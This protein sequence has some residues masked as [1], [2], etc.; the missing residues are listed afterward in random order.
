MLFIMLPVLVVFGND[1]LYYAFNGYELF[2]SNVFPSLFPFLVVVGCLV[3]LGAFRPKRRF[4]G[5]EQ[6]VRLL[7]ELSFILPLF[8][9]AAL[10]GAPSGS[11]LV[12]SALDGDRY[13]LAEKSVLSAFLNLCCPMFLLTTVSCRFL[14]RTVVPFGLILLVSH[15]SAS[16]L[17]TVGFV[18]YKYF[19]EKRDTCRTVG[20]QSYASVRLKVDD[21]EPNTACRIADV[22]PFAVFD[23]VTTMLKMLGAFV[24]FCVFASLTEKA[25]LSLSFPPVLCAMLTGLLEMT[26]G[27]A[28]VCSI[29]LPL[30]YKLILISFIC[31]FAG[32]SVIMQVHTVREI[33][34]F[35]YAAAKLVHGLLAAA[36]C[37]AIC[38]VCLDGSALVFDRN[39]ASLAVGRL[40]SFGEI[41][42]L[43]CFASALSLLITVFAVRK[44][45]T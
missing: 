5:S 32:F 41:A 28:R 23:A 26:N 30:K 44:T 36:V 4:T 33:D 27:I 16:F 37:A 10:C 42:F 13:S 35:K 12:D 7:D 25:L 9:A 17:L 34:L 43:S 15:V 8:P 6:G 14:G 31:S 24:F 29:V 38:S 2:I 22:F 39:D 40:I 20:R 1:A 3:R 21:A 18:F 11:L 19:K 45:R